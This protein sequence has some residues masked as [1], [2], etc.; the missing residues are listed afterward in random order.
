MRKIFIIIL[1]IGAIAALSIPAMLKDK[2]DV[3]QYATP[4]VIEKHFD[5]PEEPLKIE[6]SAIVSIRDIQGAEVNLTTYNSVC[7]EHKEEFNYDGRWLDDVFVSQK[8]IPVKLENDN[9]ALIYIDFIDEYYFDGRTSTIT[10][11]D[12][13][14]IRGTPVSDY[15][16]TGESALGEITI[17]VSNIHVAKF[18][19]E[20]ANKYITENAYEGVRLKKYEAGKYWPMQ[21]DGKIEIITTNDS[22][23]VINAPLLIYNMSGCDDNYIPCKS[24]SV[25]KLTNKL[26]LKYGTLK[27]MLNFNDIKE[28]HLNRTGEDIISNVFLKNGKTL[29]NAIIYNGQ[30][31]IEPEYCTVIG[32]IGTFSKGL[33]YIPIENVKNVK[34]DL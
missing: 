9:Y 22:L 33:L 10:L 23:Q 20:L 7:Q 28:I 13:K 2:K 5:K 11:T 24:F 21:F 29:N 26:P 32:F 14:V 15:N 4:P 19:A 34:N 8:V 12:G 1:I 17:P 31:S 25:W 6:K 3:Q 16:I 27:T 18:N 30:N